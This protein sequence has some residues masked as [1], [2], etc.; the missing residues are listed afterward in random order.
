VPEWSDEKFDPEFEFTNEFHS[1]V[2][3]MQNDLFHTPENPALG[4]Q[5]F[6]EAFDYHASVTSSKDGFAGIAYNYVDDLPKLK[7]LLQK[8]CSTNNLLRGAKRAETVQYLVNELNLDVNKMDGGRY[9]LQN[10]L[11]DHKGFAQHRYEHMHKMLKMGIPFDWSIPAK[12]PNGEDDIP[13]VEK[14]R[15]LHELYEE[16][17]AEEEAFRKKYRRPS[18]RPPFINS[19]PI[20]QIL[21][22]V[23]EQSWLDN[24]LD[25]TGGFSGEK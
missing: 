25:A 18:G 4:L 23:D 1:S 14:L 15:I 22:I 21:G 5:R 24:R 17:R 20:K 2:K 6:K 7:Y 9:P 11:S 10:Y 12:M 19:K 8:G 13:M 3:V 16:M